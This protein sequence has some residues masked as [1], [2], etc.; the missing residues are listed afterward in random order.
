MGDGVEGEDVYGQEEQII[1]MQRH[2]EKQYY[3]Y[4]GTQ[5]KLIVYDNGT[6]KTIKKNI[7]WKKKIVLYDTKQQVNDICSAIS[8]RV[9]L[10]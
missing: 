3:Q 4:I 6:N 8:F 9:G 7:Y 5:K 1:F 2:P 10:V